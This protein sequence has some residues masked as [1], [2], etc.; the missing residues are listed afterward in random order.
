VNDSHRKQLVGFLG[1]AKALRASMDAAVAASPEDVWK[2]AG[3]RIFARKYN[4]IVLPAGKLIKISAPLDVVRLDKMPSLGGSWGLQQKEYFEAVHANL[5]IFIAFLEQEL[6]VIRD[7]IEALKDFLQARLRAAIHNLPER[8]TDVQNAVEVLLIGRGL[9]KGIDYDR[10][11]G[12]TKV[13]VKESVPDFIFPRLSL[14][15]EVKLAKD[16]SRLGALVDQIN[17]DIR[18]YAVGYGKL[19]FLVYDIGTIR[20]ETEFKTGLEAGQISLL[21]VKH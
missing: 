17:A 6:D 15:L 14:A 13:S 18:S 16:S 1:M 20:D 4:E 19:V 2:H 12:R 5:S 7:E 9:Q 10:E 8:E 11:S 21:I 3:F